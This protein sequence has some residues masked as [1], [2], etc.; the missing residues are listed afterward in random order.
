M[1]PANGSE[2]MGGNNMS[3]KDFYTDKKM[4]ALIK[5]AEKNKIDTLTELVNE[6][7][8]PNTF[9]KEYMTPL[10]WMLWH[11]NKK[12]LKALLAV[13][14]N[15]NLKDPSGD[16]PMA[17]MAG[18]KDTEF[19]NI[20]LEGGGDPDIKTDLG[21][22]AM[23]NAIGQFRIENVKI[24]IDYGADINATDKSG[25]TPVMYAAAL[26]QYHIVHYLLEQGA[27][28]SLR[29]RGEM[30]LAWIV[31]NNKVNP[32]FE[33]YDIRKKVINML[34]EWGVRFPVPR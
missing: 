20:L 12:A 32:Q 1:I 16:S 17:M 5:A 4:L 23:F 18:A 26:N 30:S 19:M 24:L 27:D 22:P 8:D 21:K 3:I 10:M 29:T 34:K 2:S 13:G 14:A 11:K 31:Q 25:K 33:A 6:G 9:G 15:P 28:H 7:V